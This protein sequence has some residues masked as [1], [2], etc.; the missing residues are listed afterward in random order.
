MHYP[1]HPIHSKTDYLSLC[2]SH[3]R[4]RNPLRG[5]LPRTQYV[6]QPIPPFY[7]A[8]VRTATPS[9][10]SRLCQ[11]SP[12]PMMSM[13]TLLRSG[14]IH[15]NIVGWTSSADPGFGGQRDDGI[16]A[17]LVNLVSSVRTLMR[18]MCP[19]L[20]SH[21]LQFLYALA[22][23]FDHPSASVGLISYTQITWT[24]AGSAS[25][26]NVMNFAGDQAHRSNTN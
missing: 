4:N 11:F 18:S 9:T 26:H 24:F 19:A 21:L 3:K 16:K 10:P 23:S 17:R 20:H 1:N 8:C 22:R 2:P 13:Y 5:P 12:H 6:Y 14:L 25:G 7:A 15:Y